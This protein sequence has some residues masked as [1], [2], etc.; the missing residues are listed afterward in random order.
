MD[1]CELCKIN[2]APNTVPYTVTI[3][4]DAYSETMKETLRAGTQIT[5]HLPVCKLCM[6]EQ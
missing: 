2:P 4:E 5:V 3:K 6:D 1:T